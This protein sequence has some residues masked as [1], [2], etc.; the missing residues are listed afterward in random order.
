MIAE[1]K[2]PERQ[3][4]TDELIKQ[5][6]QAKATAETNY[7]DLQA[8]LKSAKSLAKSLKIPLSEALQVLSYQELKQIHWHIDQ[9]I[10]RPSNK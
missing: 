4:H 10:E 7:R 1:P 6:K 9:I 3:R 5:E 8:I 2:G